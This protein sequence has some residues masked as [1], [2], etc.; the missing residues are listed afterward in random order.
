MKW[1]YGL[2][3]AALL[4]VWL[5]AAG[6]MDAQIALANGPGGGDDATRL[7]PI[8]LFLDAMLIPKMAMITCALALIAATIVGAIGLIMALARQSAGARVIASLLGLAGAATSMLGVLG[9]LYGEQMTRQG[10]AATGITNPMVIAPGRA[11]SLLSLSFGAFAGFALLAAA[12][13]ICIVSLVRPA[14]PAL[15]TV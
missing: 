5:M 13:L 4:V 8:T 11:E 12:F 10:M 1:V 9:W 6:A 3:A 2:G 7:T 14:R 15:A